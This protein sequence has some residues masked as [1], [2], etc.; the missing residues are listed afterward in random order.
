VAVLSFDSMTA[1]QQGLIARGLATAAD[2]MS[3]PLA[4]STADRHEGR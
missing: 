2:A 3:S 1:T 4:S